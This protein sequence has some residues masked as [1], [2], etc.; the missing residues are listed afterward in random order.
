MSNVKHWAQAFAHAD[1]QN[2]R[3]N[4][5]VETYHHQLKSGYLP[6]TSRARPD[7]LVHMLVRELEPDLKQDNMAVQWNFKS[8]VT[9][10]SQRVARATAESYSMDTLQLLG[11]RVQKNDNYYFVDSLRNPTSRTYRLKYVKAGTHTKA[12]VSNCNC[13]DF[14]KGKLA[15]KH[16]YL[17]ARM[18]KLAVIED[19]S[20]IYKVNWLA[21]P[22]GNVSG[23]VDSAQG[24]RVAVNSGEAASWP[25]GLSPLDGATEGRIPIVQPVP[26]RLPP[27]AGPAPDKSTSD[28][29]ESWPANIGADP[30]GL[31]AAFRDWEA[32]RLALEAQPNPTHIDQPPSQVYWDEARKRTHPGLLAIQ[33]STSGDP[34][35]ST[36]DVPYAHGT[37][38]RLP[39]DVQVAL[40]RPLVNS[41][42]QIADRVKNLN[43]AATRKKLMENAEPA[44]LERIK[45]AAQE[46][47]R[48]LKDSLSNGRPTK[49]S[50]W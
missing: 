19:A 15:C 11:I 3:T 42:F 39:H 43:T 9:N 48:A 1:N 17:V 24:T 33:T 46:F 23:F 30:R 13:P 36:S 20:S 45:A 31:Q 28:R 12:S 35:A 37:G 16:M 18:D 38:E 2:I 47:E 10:K 8:Q 29:L 40:A 7:D 26:I 25:Q 32:E 4:N 22:Y 14:C 21:G 49:Q 27:I 41:T 6:P 50:K 5:L 34:Q 44:H